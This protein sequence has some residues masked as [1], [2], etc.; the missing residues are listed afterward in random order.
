MRSLLFA[1][2]ISVSFPAFAQQPFD[3]RDASC[4]P[5]ELKG[6]L[7]EVEA[8]FGK[9]NIVS[10]RRPGELTDILRIPSKHAQCKAVDFTISPKEA[11]ADA[12]K[13]L[14]EQP[15]EVI[16]YTGRYNHIH[17]GI[18][19]YKTYRVIGPRATDLSPKTRRN[20]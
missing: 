5:D 16:V 6:L 14:M 20:A 19:N 4:L 18:G 2:L 10:V 3:G 12:V 8:R 7:L 17:L 13:W 15:Y 9:V 1:L 11:Q